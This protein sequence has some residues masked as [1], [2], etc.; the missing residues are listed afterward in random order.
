MVSPSLIGRSDVLRHLEDEFRSARSGQGRVVVVRGEAGIG[1]SAVLDLAAA[2]APGMEVVRTCGVESERALPFAGLQQLCTT[3][4]ADLTTLDSPQRAAVEVAFGV[5]EGQADPYLVG[6]AARALLTG[7]AKARP[8]LILIDDAHWLDTPTSRALA[9]AVRRLDAFPIAVVLTTCTDADDEFAQFPSLRLTGLSDADGRALLRT[10]S[11][12]G[13]DEA[14]LSRIVAEARGNPRD[15]LAAVDGVMSPDFAGGYGVVG[16]DTGALGERI[17]GLTGAE[18]LALILAAADPT[19][20]PALQWRAADVL[21]LDRQVTRTLH[22]QGWLR[23]ETRVLFVDPRLRPVVYCLATSSERDEVHLALATATD[24]VVARDRRA[25]HLAV[26]TTGPDDQLAAELEH[27]AAHAR[28]RCG[29]GG[30]AAFLERSAL[31]TRDADL[32]SARLLAAAVAKFDIGS[33]SAAVQLLAAA[34]LGRLDGQ[35]RRCLGRQHARLAFV[36]KRNGPAAEQ[37]LRAAEELRRANEPLACEGFLEALVAATYA[38]RLGPGT[39]AFARR[40]PTDWTR[41]G[42]T[43]DLLVGLTARFATGFAASHQLLRPTVRA[44][45]G[46]DGH[47][48]SKR[49]LGIASRIAADLWDD[50][51]WDDLTSRTVDIARETGSLMKLPYAL[52]DRCLAE[53]HFGNFDTAQY[54]LDRIDAL[55]TSSHGPGFPCGALLLDGWRGAEEAAH[56]RIEA[57]RQEAMERGEGIVITTAGLSAAVLA[58]GLGRYDAALAAARDV[59]ADDELV[60]Y[61]WGLTEL[62]EAAARSGQPGAAESALAALAE[63]A[64]AVGT[65][66]ALGLEARSRALLADGTE[67][68]RLY[69]LAIDHLSRTRVVVHLARTQLVYGEWLRREGRRVDARVQLKAARDRL[70]AAGATAFTERAHR[71]YLATGDRARRRIVDHRAQLTPQETSIAALAGQGLTNPEIGERLFLSPRTVEYHLHKVFEKFGI[72]SRRALLRK[73]TPDVAGEHG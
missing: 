12:G 71:E 68:E 42:R 21:G 15:I 1:R 35:V 32:R 52:T 43:R 31:L 14:V 45:A 59:V 24:A 6:L 10:A 38:G 25:W 73:L 55:T 63:R 39:G 13:V 5:T 17:A 19:G 11:Y 34:G 62:I 56:A 60:L 69:Q 22:D 47:H 36:D 8:A 58:N 37:M 70:A 40:T 2:D 33:A 18:R 7:V 44:I 53:L 61:G 41:D 23:Q 66:W 46:R 72:S 64:R 49:W 20:D 67:A 4:R 30:E 65:D 29:R 16:A 28:R 27:C 3:L 26:A 57:A 54:L 50:D 48:A 51:L 9:F